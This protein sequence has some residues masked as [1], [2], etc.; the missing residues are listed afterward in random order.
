MGCETVLLQS[1]DAPVDLILSRVIGLS[2]L[3]QFVVQV[4]CLHVHLA[5]EVLNLNETTLN[6]QRFNKKYPK[7]SLPLCHHGFILFKCVCLSVF[8]RSNATMRLKEW[9]NLP[10]ESL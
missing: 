3:A 6:K 1:C 10:L 4:C 7:S 5:K 2:F 9:D 8:K